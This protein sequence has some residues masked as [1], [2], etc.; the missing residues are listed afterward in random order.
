M[1]LNS[2]AAVSGVVISLLLV[3]AC[4]QKHPNYYGDDSYLYGNIAWPYSHHYATDEDGN[5]VVKYRK[6]GAPIFMKPRGSVA[7]YPFPEE[8]KHHE[9]KIYG[10]AESEWNKMTPGQQQII[11]NNYERKNSPKKTENKT[12][13][14]NE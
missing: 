5:P 3:S 2:I 12:L 1:K 14:T 8:A 7:P 4:Q 10:V 6:D 13:E 11:R 9:S